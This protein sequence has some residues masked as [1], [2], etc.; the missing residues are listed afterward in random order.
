MFEFLVHIPGPTYLVIYG[1]GTLV[2]L[3]AAWYMSL[4]DSLRYKEP[5]P[6]RHDPI[7][8]AALLGRSHVIRTVLF[9]LWSRNL[10]RFEG[11][12]E[13]PQVVANTGPEQ[14]KNGFEK[15]LLDFLEQGHNP[16][17]LFTNLNLRRD[18]DKELAP[19][20]DKL[21][22]THLLLDPDTKKKKVKIAW[23]V[24]LVILAAGIIKLIFGVSRN[25]PVGF[26][27]LEMIVGL[28]LVLV[29]LKP[30]RITTR[31]GHRYLNS[32]KKHFDWVKS[33]ME[34]GKVPNGMDPALPLAVFGTGMFTNIPAF[35]TFQERFGRSTHSSTTG[36]GGCSVSS[37]DGGGGGGCGGGCGGC[38][39]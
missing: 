22:G 5:A 1:I 31:L 19:I 29:V 25:K 10:V 37:S 36:C 12:N 2:I 9:G 8:V 20:Q 17:V 16:L 15:C 39:G 28:I 3:A 27:I 30:W 23:M 6:S 21:I 33:A 18:F 7:T 24:A 32:L 34:G 14:G 11:S 26:L 4:D 38:G 35:Q 13:N